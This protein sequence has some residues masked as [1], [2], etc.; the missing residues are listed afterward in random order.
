M[1]TSKCNIS[2]EI[3]I[4]LSST[5]L[6]EACNRLCVYRLRHCQ[7]KTLAYYMRLFWTISCSD[8]SF[9]TMVHHSI[10][11][12][13][14]FDVNYWKYFC[15]IVLISFMVCIDGYCYNFSRPYVLTGQSGLPII[16][17]ELLK[18]GGAVTPVNTCGNRAFW[19]DSELDMGVV[20]GE[21]W[22]NTNTADSRRGK[23]NEEKVTFYH[24]VRSI[25]ILPD[26]F[27]HTRATDHDKVQLWACTH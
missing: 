4:R 13:F 22:K 23:R 20:L 11:R 2:F 15:E 19:L 12:Y 26:E 21:A 24:F 5:P 3:K 7:I 10:T 1:R 27:D 6:C 9:N 17:T 25:W 18:M 8:T 14:E 16:N